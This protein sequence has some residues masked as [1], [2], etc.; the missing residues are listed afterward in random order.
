[1]KTLITYRWFILAAAALIAAVVELHLWMPD[2]LWS[3][4]VHS[5][6]R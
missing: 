4:R 6:I 3:L 5:L 2:L 1:M